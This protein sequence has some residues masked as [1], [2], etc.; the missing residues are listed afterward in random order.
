M[1]KKG[2]DRGVNKPKLVKEL[3]EI[4]NQLLGYLDKNPGATYEELG[5][6][7]GMSKFGV[8]KRYKK[9]HF[10]AAL[11]EIS[12]STWDL[13]LRAKKTSARNLLKLAGSKDPRIAMDAAKLLF[14]PTLQD[15]NINVR[16]IKEVIYRTKF[17]ESGEL[18]QE[19]EEILEDPKNALELL[20]GV[21]SE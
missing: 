16:E 19:T 21:K 6:H 11:A 5:Q 20:S 12:K 13:I 18:L 17:G 3:D 15:T 4:D 14:G 2:V 8:S 9:P 10:Q 1:A 7:V